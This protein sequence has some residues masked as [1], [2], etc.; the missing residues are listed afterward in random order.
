VST[1]DAIIRL[2]VDLQRFQEAAARAAFA[3]LDFGYVSGH[4]PEVPRS[5]ELEAE[6]ERRGHA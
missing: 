4:E 6:A 1:L 5:P 3:A 2:T